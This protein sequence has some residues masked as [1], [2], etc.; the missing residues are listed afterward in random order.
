VEYL[1][2]KVGDSLQF[3]FYNKEKTATADYY[4][5]HPTLHNFLFVNV[6]KCASQ[7]VHAWSMQMATGGEIKE[8]YRFTILREPYGRLKSTFAYAVGAKYQ[9]KFSV[10]EIGDWFFGKNLPE[11]LT[12][13][14]VDLFVHFVPQTVFVENAPIEIDHWYSTGDMRQLRRKLSSVSG[15]NIQWIQENTSRYTEDFTIKYN[16]WFTENKTWIDDHL[17]K[18]LELYSMH[19]AS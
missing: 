12:P 18:D 6:P 16:K 3:R 10:E 2:S 17:A 5:S 19:V 1:L 13:N 8:P 7:T 11:E 9:Y 4:C 14:H 15:I